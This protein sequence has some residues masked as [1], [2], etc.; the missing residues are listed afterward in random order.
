MMDRET[1]V[2]EDLIKGWSNLNSKMSS[3]K[4]K[5]KTETTQNQIKNN[6]MHILTASL[7]IIQWQFSLESSR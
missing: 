6:W 1:G 7:T 5:I 4:K 2:E 3:K